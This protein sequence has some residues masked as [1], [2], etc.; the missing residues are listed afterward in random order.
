M[1]SIIILIFLI[2]K[3]TKLNLRWYIN[4]LYLIYL[5]NLKHVSTNKKA[6]KYHFKYKKKLL[7]KIIII[8][9]KDR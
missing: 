7:V 6:T 8:T 5:N 3:T 9:T 1:K 4:I 2:L